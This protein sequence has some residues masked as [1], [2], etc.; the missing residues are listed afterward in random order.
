MS[1]PICGEFCR[2]AEPRA[3]VSRQTTLADVDAYDPSEEQFAS[4]IAGA[5]L[6]EDEQE[7]ISGTLASARERYER[8]CVAAP[9]YEPPL[10]TRM[11]ESQALQN[12]EVDPQAAQSK[13]WRNEVTS[14]L[15]NY[16]ARRRRSLGNDTMSFNFESTTGNHVFLKPEREPEPVMVQPEAEPAPSYYAPDAC[17]AEPMFQEPAQDLTEKSPSEAQASFVEF[18]EP[19]PAVV[20]APAKLIFFPKPPLAVET[21]IDELAEPVFDTPRILDAPE[22]VETVAIPLADISLH[23]DPLDDDRAPYLEPESELPV[24]VAPVAQR[25]F[26]EM[27]DTLLVLLATGVF[28]TILAH[29]APSTLAQDKRA[30][31][32]MGVVIPGIFWAVF[33]YLFIVHG[34]TTPGMQMARLQLVRFDGYAPEIGPRRYRAMAML[35]SIFPLGLGLMW[36]FVD[37]D[38]LCWHDRIS[39]TYLTAR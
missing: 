5:A 34:G 29:L 27:L 36:S 10:P 8:N 2:C 17:A 32:A 39:R 28:G 23:P 30:L 12:P 11:N 14:R 24:A 4:S 37:P 1:C 18:T 20:A 7:L 3:F 16:K 25:L 15:Q 38:T 35:V 19:E 22:S 31:L 13:E 6:P 33:K 26:A 21:R 9:Q